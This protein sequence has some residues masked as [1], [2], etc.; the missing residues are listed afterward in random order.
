MPAMR[1]QSAQQMSLPIL[2]GVCTTAEA[3][4]QDAEFQRPRSSWM[5]L[6]IPS[7]S[8]TGRRPPGVSRNSL[9]LSITANHSATQTVP[10]GDPHLPNAE[11]FGRPAPQS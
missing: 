8:A 5:S 9:P 3:S 4:Q 2:V 1:K 10:K 6:A 7:K 11:K